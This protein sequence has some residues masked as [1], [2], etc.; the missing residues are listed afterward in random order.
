M[1]KLDFAGLSQ[2]LLR[3]ALNYCMLWLPGG[4]LKGQEYVCAD[5]TG[6]KG[7][8]LSVNIRTGKWADF[9]TGEKGR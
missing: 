8:S 2:H 4:D 9:A 6:G 5:L 7:S 3:D 1:K